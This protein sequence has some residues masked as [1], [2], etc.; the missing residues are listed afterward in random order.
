MATSA[1]IMVFIILAGLFLAAHSVAQEKK[2][3]RWTDENGVVHYSDV[4]PQGQSAQEQQIPMDRSPGTSNPDSAASIAAPSIA[5]QKR[6][7]IADKA[8][9]AKAAKAANAAK[10][11]AWKS[12][13]QQLEP[14]RRV[15]Y[16]NDQGETER[17]DDVARTDRVKELK[18][19]IAQN[20]N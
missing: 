17:M 11:S 16:T 18:S 13:V 8:D 14:N 7:D 1:K 6:Q 20:C 3:Y 2:M 5:E 15:F 4:Q 10:C 19:L 12:E 9:Q